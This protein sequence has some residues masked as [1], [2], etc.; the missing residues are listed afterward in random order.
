MF[1]IHHFFHRLKPCGNLSNIQNPTF[2]IK[3]VHA[4]GIF[5]AINDCIPLALTL[6]ASNVIAIVEKQSQATEVSR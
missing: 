1:L 5:L 6:S 3:K 4:E 2:N